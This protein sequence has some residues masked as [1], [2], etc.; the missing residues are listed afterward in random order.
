MQAN[1]VRLRQGFFNVGNAP[2]EAVILREVCPRAD[3]GVEVYS[4]A[5]GWLSDRCCRYLPLVIFC[6]VGPGSTLPQGVSCGNAWLAF[7]VEFRW[8]SL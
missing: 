4:L 7:A 1:S 8:S 3:G 6:K 2:N 5:I